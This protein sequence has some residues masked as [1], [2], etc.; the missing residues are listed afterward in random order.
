MCVAFVC[1][2]VWEDSVCVLCV[3]VYQW[4]DSVCVLC[5]SGRTLCVCCVSVCISGRTLCVCCVSVCVSGR[6]LCV[7]CVSVCVSGRTL[8]VSPG[9]GVNLVTL[10]SVLLAL[11]V[12]SSGFFGFLAATPAQMATKYSDLELAL[13]TLVTEFHKG[14]DD[15][16]TMNTTQFQTLISKQMP[17]LAKTVENEEGL[18]QVLE[19]M[20]VHSGQNISFDNFWKLINKQAVD[21]FSATYKEKSTMC[22]CLLQ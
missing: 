3:S 2:S 22:N 19:Q 10:R 18:G 12:F 9:N 14:A 7:C 4:E 13:N 6:T 1:L 17:V 16:S 21:L 5:V 11:G 8:C 15:A 20:G